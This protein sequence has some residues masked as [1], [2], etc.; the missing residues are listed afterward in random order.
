MPEG[1]KFV[2]PIPFI[3]LTWEKER[4]RACGKE[5]P[6]S[7]YLRTVPSA[8]YKVGGQFS[9]GHHTDSRLF[10]FSTDGVGGGVRLGC[11]RQA[12]VCFL[13]KS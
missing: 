2:S 9:L 10:F 6:N 12:L 11:K 13:Q 7:P 1:L 3:H 4:Q 8:G 5:L